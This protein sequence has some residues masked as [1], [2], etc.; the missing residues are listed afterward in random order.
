MILSF[1]VTHGN[2]GIK[3][4]YQMGMWALGFMTQMGIKA[5]GKIFEANRRQFMAWEKIL[6]LIEDNSW[7]VVKLIFFLMSSQEK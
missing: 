7:L 1:C 5:L 4:N 2:M 6:K 3:I